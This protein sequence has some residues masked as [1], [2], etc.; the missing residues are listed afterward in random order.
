[1]TTR[2]DQ[3]DSEQLQPK[4][5]RGT[6]SPAA[7]RKR[8]APESQLTTDGDEQL[9][10]LRL[11]VGR[12]LRELRL[13]RGIGLRSLAAGSGV[14]SGFLSQ[15]ESGRVMPSIASLVNICAV[16]QVHVGDVFDAQ[17]S[18]ARLIRSADRLVYSYPES[19]IRD[20]VLTADPTYRIEVVHSYFAPKGSTG[21][22]PYSH[23]SQVEA[24]LVL[25]GQLVINLGTEQFTL[26]A[27]DTLTF[28]GTLLHEIS[29]P[30]DRPAEAIWVYSPATY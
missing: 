8:H 16:L 7:S 20:E 29:N 28:P 22:Q 3:A 9:S 21:R 2:R 1:M 26:R 12:R 14:T 5:G 17:G 13:E 27:G 23:G 10:E 19:G 4:K 6:R 25:K 15:V 24:A 18:R 30:L 11:L